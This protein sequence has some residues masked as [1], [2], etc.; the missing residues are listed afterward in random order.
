MKMITIIRLVLIGLGAF[1]FSPLNAEAP[2]L[3]QSQIKGLLVIQLPNG[4]FAGAATQMN[5]TVVPIPK[6]SQ[7]T[8]GI[9]FNQQVGP[10]MF[11]ATQE[12]EKM[13]RIRHQKDLPTG[14]GIELGFA[15]KYTMKDGPSAAVACALMAES[16]IT[17]EALEPSFAVTGD[18]TATGEVRPIGGVAGKVRGAANRDCKI[19]AVPSANKAAIQDIYVMEGIEP[20]AATQI[21]L[22]ENFDQ[23]WDIA[24]AKRS[25]KIQQALD[26][27]A[28]VQ[29]AIAKSP[30]SA[31]HPK[32]RD[33]LKSILETL[34][35]HESARLIALHGMAKG[36]KKLSLNGSLAAIQTA[37]TELGSTIQNGSYMEKG[38]GNQ[39]WKNVS[40][41]N[42]LREDVDPR[43]KNYL[44]AF[45]NTAN[46]LKKIST[47]EKKQLTDDLQRELMS[48]INKIGVEENKLLNDTK[49]QEEIMKE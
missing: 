25:E 46:I 43:T 21:I 39:L 45:L 22:I 24:K 11:G 32:V 3:Q 18:M 38:Q 6:N 41:L 36:P 10:M 14:H 31:S 30:T 48:S 34:P 5:A 8:F 37:A 4:S 23:A 33:K 17:G 40:R 19:M 42:S 16:I 12:V 47:S 20:I 29:T 35:N 15:D 28:M 7:I 44:D 26:D 1:S 27:Y 49:I 2:K 9:R 13:M